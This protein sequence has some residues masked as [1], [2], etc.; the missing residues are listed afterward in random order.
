[1]GRNGTYSALYNQGVGIVA[2]VCFLY[3]YC[4]ALAYQYREGN[5]MSPTA[6]MA[7]Q[8]VSLIPKAF[9]LSSPTGWIAIGVIL[10]I[11]FIWYWIN[12]LR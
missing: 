9:H 7:A 3:V 11:F 8:L 2:G 10:V 4:R 1:M 12:F 6:S 5:T